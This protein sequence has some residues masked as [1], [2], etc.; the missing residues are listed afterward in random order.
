[1]AGAPCTSNAGHTYSSMYLAKHS[2]SAG[3]RSILRSRRRV[4]QP[5]RLHEIATATNPRPCCRASDQRWSACVATMWPSTTTTDGATDGAAAFPT[6][7]P[8]DEELR[9]A[10]G[11]FSPPS[12]GSDLLFSAAVTSVR[13]AGQFTCSAVS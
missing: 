11:A 10:D 1:M 3:G 6:R 5:A 12:D 8:S 2:V 13:S 4:R 9:A 7:V